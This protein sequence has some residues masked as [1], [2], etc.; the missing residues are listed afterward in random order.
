[1]TV[2]YR[3]GE[4][5]QAATTADYNLVTGGTVLSFTNDLPVAMVCDIRIDIGVDGLKELNTPSASYL[6]VTLTVNSVVQATT[7]QKGANDTTFIA[8]SLAVPVYTGEALTVAV[9]SSDSADTD[10]T[11]VAT[12]TDRSLPVGAIY[13]KVN[14]AAATTTDFDVSLTWTDAEHYRNRVAI[15]LDGTYKGQAALIT[16]G[17]S[18]NLTLT[19]GHLTAAPANGTFIKIV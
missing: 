7:Y 6:T 19:S 8:P 10:V 15:L 18:P 11:V 3:G 2:P 13:T 17:T 12:I 16:G 9:T 1:M 14:D 5:L 4:P